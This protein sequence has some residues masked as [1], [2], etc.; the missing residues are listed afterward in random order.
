MPVIPTYKS[1]ILPIVR[2]PQLMVP[3]TAV[4]TAISDVGK[5][6]AGIGAKFKR[7]EEVAQYNENM[8]SLREELT[9]LRFSFAERQDFENFQEDFQ[10]ETSG[11]AKKHFEGMRD[12]S[13]WG[14]FEAHM[15]GAIISTEAAVRSMKRRK[16]IDFGRASYSDAMEKMAEDYGKATEVEKKNL[17]VQAEDIT[18]LNAEVGHI[19]QQEAQ[20]ALSDFRHN[21]MRSDVW[22]SARLMGYEEGIKWL[23]NEKNA[24]QLTREE[25][26]SMIAQLRRDWNIQK[27]ED[28]EKERKLNDFT[29]DAFLE[30]IVGWERGE[31]PLPTHTEIMGSPLTDPKLKVQLMSY[32][33][34]VEKERNPFLNS[35]PKIFADVISGLYINLEDWNRDRIINYMGAGLSTQHTLYALKE[36]ERLITVPSPKKDSQ[37]ALSIKILNRAANEG[38]FIGKELKTEATDKEIIDNYRMHAKL[39][40]ELVNRSKEEDP[41]EVTRELMKPYVDRKIEHWMTKAWRD[42]FG[43][44]T[45]QE[46]ERIREEATQQLQEEGELVTE[47][48]INERIEE[49]RKRAREG[50]EEI[51]VDEE[52]EKVIKGSVEEVIEMIRRRRA[53][54]EE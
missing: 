39:I 25:R 27:V 50:E 33:D 4:S 15:D 10:K 3:S 30:K 21:A 28:K 1:K 52:E 42:A 2:A 17:L 20:K 44:T 37:L 14:S 43:R 38:M 31:G 12:N 26:N 29:Y 35:D 23:Q 24:P 54:E 11:I 41:V 40:A 5:Q 36:Y 19:S 6:V 13:F 46:E 9:E 51:E 7:A 48:S 45:V 22:H 34:S 18:N 49:I 8:K 16:Q 53:G 32:L 47:D